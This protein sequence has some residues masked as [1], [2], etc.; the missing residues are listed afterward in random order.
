[1]V[2]SAKENKEKERER[3]EER[4]NG[5]K[6]DENKAVGRGNSRTKNARKRGR[7]V[8]KMARRTSTCRN[9][10]GNCY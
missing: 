6:W 7:G 5:R 9:F 4:R 3:A 2:A 1:M 8:V 10:Y